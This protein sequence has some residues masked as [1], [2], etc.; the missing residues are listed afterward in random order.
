MQTLKRID[1]WLVVILICYLAMS[2]FM[3]AKFPKMWVDD[4]WT[5]IIPHTMA[6][7]GEIR[8]PV[9]IGFEGRD[10]HYVA[11]DVLFRFAL[12]GWYKVFGFGIARSRALPVVAGLLLLISTYWFARRYYGYRTALIATALLAIDNVFF[13]TARTI[14]GDMFLALFSATAFF[15]SYHGLQ[16]GALRYFIFAGLLTGLSWFTHPL[17]FPISVAILIIFLVNYKATI[18]YKKEFWKFSIAAFIAFLPYAVY[19]VAEDYQYRFANFFLQLGL[20]ADYGQRNFFQDLILELD[21]YRHYIYFPRRLLIFLVQAVALVY[22]LTTLRK[23]DKYLVFGSLCFLLLLPFLYP[24][25]SSRAFIVI[26]PFISILVAQFFLDLLNKFDQAVVLQKFKNWRYALVGIVIALFFL[27]HTAGN[28]YILWKH[29]DHDFYAF[30]EQVRDTI[31]EGSKIWGSITF[32]FGLHDYPYISEISNFK[33]VYKFKPDYAIIYDN[34]NW[35]GVSA[36]VARTEQSTEWFYGDKT[37]RIEEL[38]HSR[39]DFVKEIKNRFYGD[40]QIFKLKW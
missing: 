21:R 3:L 14:R 10:K 32:W 8:N 39:G 37:T 24:T 40:I 5:A 28:A 33:E 16:S 6:T 31:P 11:P 34:M 2:F 15:L 30:I 26:L 19:V 13:V 17:S 7:K 9:L 25:A 29:R 20:Y 12:A 36:I 22:A 35:G 1:K 4:A 38:C 27:N 23:V 18:I